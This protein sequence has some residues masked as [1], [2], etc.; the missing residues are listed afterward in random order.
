MVI[1]L[2]IVDPEGDTITIE[3]LDLPAG[4]SL[5]VA[6]RRLLWTPTTAQVGTHT[7]RLLVG[8]RNPA[9]M[10]RE[11]VFDV[12]VL[13]SSS[14][15]LALTMTESW[16][17]GYCGD[18]EWTNDTGAPVRDW[19]ILMG[20]T[21]DVFAYWSGEFST[22]AGGYL[23]EPVW[24]NEELP[25][26]ATLQ[27]GFCAAGPAPSSVELI[28]PDTET[29]EGADVLISYLPEEEDDAQET[30]RWIEQAGRKAVAFPG[31][32]RDESVCQALVEE[33]HAA[34]QLLIR[35]RARYDARRQ[36]QEGRRLVRLVRR[37]PEVFIAIESGRPR[38]KARS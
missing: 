20:L 3:A 24:Y 34:E 27:V 35:R 1:P 17:G 18:I 14:Q 26:G 36:A 31:D 4:V 2:T 22:V 8:D 13:P 15:V 12:E 37:S 19:A 32:I 25:P 23:I 16:G 21:A 38:P 29:V 11:L 5:D 7:F 9:P 6:G 28:L 33:Q 30:V 10:T